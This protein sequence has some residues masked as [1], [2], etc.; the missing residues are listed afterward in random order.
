MQLFNET[1]INRMPTIEIFI[2]NE[3]GGIE[4]PSGSQFDEEVMVIFP[5]GEQT[6]ACKFE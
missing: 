4:E 1:P 6:Q 2:T 3:P 5:W